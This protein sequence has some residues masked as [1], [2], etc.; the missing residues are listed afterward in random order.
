[1]FDLEVSTN[2]NPANI[3]YFDAEHWELAVNPGPV[4]V[5]PR[6]WRPCSTETAPCGCRLIGGQVKNCD[7]TKLHTAVWGWGDG[8]GQKTKTAISVKA[9]VCSFLLFFENPTHAAK[10]KTIYCLKGSQPHSS[11][12]FWMVA[13]AAVK[14]KREWVFVPVHMTSVFKVLP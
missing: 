8:G 6:R 14:C 5:S 9:E 7:D 3:H 12:W 13:V 1:M 4:S 11:N 10:M 2:S